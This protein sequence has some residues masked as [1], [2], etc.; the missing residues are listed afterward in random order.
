M[1]KMRSFLFVTSEISFVPEEFNIFVSHVTFEEGKGKGARILATFCE[2]DKVSSND[3]VYRFEEGEQMAKSL[4]GKAI[5][6]GADWKGKHYKNVPKI[7]IVEKAWVAGKKIKGIVR[8]WAKDIVAKLK[9]GIKFLFSVGGVAQFG[10]TVVKGG[11]VITKLYHAICTHLQLLSNNPKGAGFPS[12]KMHKIIEINESV[13]LTGTEDIKVCDAYGCK[14]LKD[15]KDEFEEAHKVEKAVEESTEA[16]VINRAIAE[17]IAAMIKA[18][19]KEPW[20]FMDEE[21]R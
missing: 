17:D 11:K 8:I 7:G 1:I 4:V 16:K 13:M 21:K 5:R 3:R 20:K 6:F 15:I 14:I 2:L 10:E 18:V 12:A 9:K 19:M